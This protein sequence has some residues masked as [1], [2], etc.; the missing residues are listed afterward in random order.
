MAPTMRH[1]SSRLLDNPVHQYSP[2]SKSQ[3]RRPS[4]NLRMQVME[5]TEQPKGFPSYHSLNE[6]VNQ[7]PP[8]F[9]QFPQAGLQNTPFFYTIEGQFVLPTEPSPHPTFRPSQYE[10]NSYVRSPPI[11]QPTNQQMQSQQMAATPNPAPLRSYN[12]QYVPERWQD[13]HFY[14]N[15]RPRLY[16]SNSLPIVR[17][18]KGIKRDKLP[19]RW[20]GR[21]SSQEHPPNSARCG[22]GNSQ[23]AVVAHLAASHDQVGFRRQENAPPQQPYR[24]RADS[25]EPFPPFHDSGLPQVPYSTDPQF[26]GQ[27][28]MEDF[29]CTAHRIG[30]LR[31]DVRS[32]WV[33]QFPSGTDELLLE[34]IFGQVA[35]VRTVHVR[36]GSRFTIRPF[37]FVE[38]ANPSLL[39]NIFA[40][41]HLASSIQTRPKKL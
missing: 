27:V 41:I 30:R 32:L 21:R 13:Q 14:N 36:P 40:N 28:S 8:A 24:T 17:Q 12:D 18:N 26:S 29:I 5:G 23:F 39:R 22:P 16:D 10:L 2:R 1:H 25:I 20:S 34:R 11:A 15:E 7:Q 38:L 3:E 37:A 19:N 31:E 35:H 6:V 4:L 9:T 33:S